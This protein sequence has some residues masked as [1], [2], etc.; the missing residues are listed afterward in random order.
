[1]PM[2]DYF[3]LC[4]NEFEALLPISLRHEAHCPNCG[5]LA[6]KKFSVFNW[7]FGWKRSDK[8]AWIKGYPDE[9][10]KNI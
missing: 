9:F 3:C 6:N 5:R 2:Y 10:V 4:G 7:S 1:M 8:S